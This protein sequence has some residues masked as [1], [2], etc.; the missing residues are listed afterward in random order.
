VE[1]VDQNGRPIRGAEEEE[2]A[3]TFR[4]NRVT[5]TIRNLSGTTELY[6]RIFV[7]KLNG[8]NRVVAENTV[9]VST[10]AFQIKNVRHGRT[11]TRHIRRERI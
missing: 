10:R 2:N 11:F 1:V 8:V 6:V 4:V 3:Y 9:S 7:Y 5:E